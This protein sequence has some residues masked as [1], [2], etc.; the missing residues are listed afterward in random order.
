LIADS[1]LSKTKFIDNELCGQWQSIKIISKGPATLDIDAT[2]NGDYRFTLKHHGLSSPDDEQS[3]FFGY[4][5]KTKWGNFLNIEYAFPISPENASNNWFK[6]RQQL[7]Q[8]EIFRE[9]S[10]FLE[11]PVKTVYGKNLKFIK[12]F[13]FF[14][15]LIGKN[16][17]SV[18]ALDE[19]KLA[20]D[21]KAKKLAG[22]V[23][24]T[25]WGQTVWITDDTNHILNYLTLSSNKHLFKSWNTYKRV[26]NGQLA[27]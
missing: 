10:K 6:S 3:T 17:L 25:T 5:T 1:P 24:E 26:E 22:V 14:K 27:H 21:I 13:M 7:D 16:T 11:P 23:N 8:K 2:N 9:D 15:Y 4:P 18:W 20:Q 12:T 19:E